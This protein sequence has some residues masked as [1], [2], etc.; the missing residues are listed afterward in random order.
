MYGE[1]YPKIY[2][3]YQ[4]DISGI[5]ENVISLYERVIST[6]AYNQFNV[7]EYIIAFWPNSRTLNPSSR[8]S[9]RHFV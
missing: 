5:K 8:Y 1:F 9:S 7:L 2:R 6:K 3:K 4:L